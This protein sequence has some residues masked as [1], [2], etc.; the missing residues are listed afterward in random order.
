MERFISSCSSPDFEKVVSPVSV[1][2]F[3]QYKLTRLLLKKLEGLNFS[4]CKP[5]GLEGHKNEPL[6]GKELLMGHE[7]V[8]INATDQSITVMA[9]HLE[10]GKY[11]ERNI[12][13]NILVGA[14]GAGSTVRKLV[15]IELRGEK[16]L[17]N[18]VSIHFLSRDLGQY[19]LNERPG[20]LFFIFNIE[21]I[22][23]LV[24]HDLRK[25]EFVLQ[26]HR[27]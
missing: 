26:V 2:H 27:L 5:G 9:S 20:M 16:D 10:E 18:L 19:L 15:G 6:R 7:C 8:S 21:A 22:G 3:S 12:S 11:M 25:G 23:A 24:A 14:D 13:C 4:V 1:A 17:Q